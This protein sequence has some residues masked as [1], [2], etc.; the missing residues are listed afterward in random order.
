MLWNET[1]VFSQVVAAHAFNP[2]TREVEAS[3]FEANLVY[4]MSSR[5]A[6]AT[7]RNPVL[8]KTTTKRP[9]LACPAIFSTHRMLTALAHWTSNLFPLPSR[10][11]KC[12][13]YIPWKCQD[14]WES[15]MKILFVSILVSVPP[16]MSPGPTDDKQCLLLSPNSVFYHDFSTA[17]GPANERHPLTTVFRADSQLPCEWKPALLIYTR[18]HM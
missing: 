13:W 2:S 4:T 6:R 8:K 11:T 12:S 15:W 14:L 17:I 1:K 10:Y 18:Q 7:Q 16:R 9:P 5:T 3:E